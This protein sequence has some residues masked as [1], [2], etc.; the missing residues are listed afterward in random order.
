MYNTYLIREFDGA[1]GDGLD[2]DLCTDIGADRG[3]GA[4][5]V[6]IGLSCTGGVFGAVAAANAA[7]IKF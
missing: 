3:G 2:A 4:F 1:G 7:A 6:N 5:V